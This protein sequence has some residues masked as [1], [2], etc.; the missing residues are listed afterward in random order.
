MGGNF[1][2]IFI[3]FRDPFWSSRGVQW[4]AGGDNLHEPMEFHDLNHL[5][6]GFNTLFTYVVGDASLMWEALS[7]K[8][9]TAAV[10]RRLKRLFP[11]TL[12]GEPSAFYMT[13]H[14]SDP[15]I[16]GSYSTASMGANETLFEAMIAPIRTCNRSR[17]FF[18]GEHTCAA[19]TGYLHGAYFSGVGAARDVLSLMGMPAPPLPTGWTC[20]E[21]PLMRA[22]RRSR[23]GQSQAHN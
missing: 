17:V 23:H 15:F 9:A 19:Y 14:S 13:R 21:V 3:Q 5:V 6:P 11:N 12:I 10:I 18:A 2:K 16:R 22:W 4:L 1:T 8:E 20:Q 7:D